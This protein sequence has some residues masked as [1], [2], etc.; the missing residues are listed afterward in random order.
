[1]SVIRTVYIITARRKY[2]KN[3]VSTSGAWDVDELSSDPETGINRL[4]FKGR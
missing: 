3:T 2:R 4:I 1:M